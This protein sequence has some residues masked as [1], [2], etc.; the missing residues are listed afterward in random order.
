M[1]QML[2]KKVRLKA[3]LPKSRHLKPEKIFNKQRNQMQISLLQRLVEPKQVLPPERK[4]F[5]NRDLV[6][7]LLPIVA[8]QFSALLVGIADTLMVSHAGER[9]VSGVSLVNQLNNVFIMVFL[10]LAA[11]GSVVSS[12][13]VGSKEKENGIIAAS[14]LVMITTVISVVL[15]GVVLVFGSNLFGML[16]GAVEP[17][18]Y[19]DGMTYLRIS[20]YSFVG[21]AVYNA[22]AGLYRS[23]GKT[24]EL[25]YVF[26]AMNGINIIGN[27]IGIFVLH[28]GVEGVAYPSLIS[29]IFAAVVML[30]LTFNHNNILYLC[31]KDLLTWNWKMIKRI[32][33]IAIPNSIENGL[34]QISKVALSSIVA[35]FGTRQIAAN[36]VAQSF[37]SMA[38]LFCLAMG[39][40]FITV[41]GQYMGAKD[42]EGAE[43]YMKKLLRITYLGGILWNLVFFTISPLLLMFYDLS[44]ETVRLVLI[45]TLCP[46]SFSLSSG[47][48]AAGDV[49]FNLYASIFSTVICRVVLSVLFGLVFNMG[50]I[51]ITL[52]MT[53]DWGIKALMVVV[54]YKHGK[55]KHFNLI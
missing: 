43:Y 20:A 8:E 42:T 12:Q 36:G 14:Q 23:M 28:A 41:V 30:I 53:C 16:F 7:L 19:K 33:F 34:F 49:E 32:F 47:L 45:L 10:A 6:R 13:Y 31:L 48:R 54:R 37:W 55:W 50:V 35:M 15:T 2:G 5:S 3:T 26:F 24:K 51:G 17:D 25:M 39:P 22:C 1:A 38:A 21:L 44:A 4:L 52:A 18:V 40:A 27:A 11:G 46:V 29:R 9:A